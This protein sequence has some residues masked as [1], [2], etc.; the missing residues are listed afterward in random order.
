MTDNEKIDAISKGWGQV[1][2]RKT[3]SRDTL[4]GTRAL[5][6]TL[7]PKGLNPT[8]P[9]WCSVANAFVVTANAEKT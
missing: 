9:R 8:K 5:S 4:A 7:L 2:E 1:T 6:K 3:W